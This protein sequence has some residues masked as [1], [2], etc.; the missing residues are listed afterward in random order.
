MRSMRGISMVRC[1]GMVVGWVASV[2]LALVAPAYAQSPGPDEYT[3]TGLANNEWGNAQNW[4]PEGTPENGDIVNLT[5]TPGGITGVPPLNLLAFN[6]EDGTYTNAAEG[7]FASIIAETATIGPS[8][9]RLELIV[10]KSLVISFDTKA[11]NNFEQVNFIGQNAGIVVHPTAT[12]TMLPNSAVVLTDGAHIENE[13]SWTVPLGS[14]SLSASSCCTDPM[15]FINRGTVNGGAG[16]MLSDLR[17]VARAGSV[18]RGGLTLNRGSHVIDGRSSVR[19]ASSVMQFAGNAT[20]ERVG[21]STVRPELRVL[22]GATVRVSDTAKVMLPLL[23]SNPTTTLGTFAWGGGSILRPVTVGANVRFD[24]EGPANKLVELVNPDHALR[25]E[26]PTRLKAGAVVTLAGRV[27]NTGRMIVSG[28]EPA[29]FVGQSCCISPYRL[30]NEGTIDG[31]EVGV[32]FDDM[33]LISRGTSVTQGTVTL[34]GGRHAFED[35]STVQGANT[36]LLGSENALIEAAGTIKLADGAAW[37]LRGNTSLLTLTSATW[38]GVGEINWWSGWWSGR[39]TTGSNVTLRIRRALSEAA[40]QRVFSAGD[41][42]TTGNSVLA[43]RGP[44]TQTALLELS[45]GGGAEA[46]VR[47]EGGWTLRGDLLGESC[48][49]FI[50]SGRLVADATAAAGVALNVGRFSSTGR[51]DVL[52]SA[53]RVTSGAPVLVSAGTVTVAEGAV[54][55]VNP[56]LNLTGGVLTGNGEVQGAVRNAATVRPTALGQFSIAGEYEQVGAGRLAIRVSSTGASRLN[57]SGGTAWL[58]GTLELSSSGG[59][60]ASATVL[61]TSSPI[62]GFFATISGGAAGSLDVTYEPNAVIVAKK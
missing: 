56:S 55:G 40:L 61:T 26:G 36:L 2:A 51:V 60:P 5:G 41:L 7:T 1:G 34:L 37:H 22:E 13:G 14:A 12:V 24:I 16:L 20:I 11:E 15:R 10:T 32:T 18:V 9:L 19:G 27:Q 23:I 30:V 35:G 8:H 62:E 54:L 53:L 47:N 21:S 4:S 6:V 43:T 28:T 52:K 38:A 25:I 42:D 39:L 48:T 44:V 57:I 17:F 3:W 33:A 49:R 59:L 46:I 58:Y 31:R 45:C 29:R 50:S